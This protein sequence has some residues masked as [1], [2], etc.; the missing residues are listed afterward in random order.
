M[1]AE[2][3]LSG[4]GVVGASGYAVERTGKFFKDV[5]PKLTDRA[6][7]YLTAKLDKW[8]NE[9]EDRLSR[10]VAEAAAKRGLGGPTKDAPVSVLYPLIEAATLE[11][12]D[13][14]RKMWAEMLLN[15]IDANSTAEVR[16][17]YVSILQ[18][19][20]PLDA[21]VLATLHADDYCRVGNPVR[22]GFLPESIS[23]PYPGGRL[24][25]QVV[26]S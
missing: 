12:D 8:I 10:S 26:C 19:C 11:D 21:K 5:F 16:R 15:A 3:I 13:E 4:A 6:D 25:I 23:P 22:S 24:L 7:T 9:R 20:K 2:L 1:V 14:L 17:A 18:D